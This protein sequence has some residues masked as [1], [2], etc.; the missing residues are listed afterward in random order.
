[1]YTR[2]SAKYSR[3]PTDHNEMEC[4]Y[5]SN[6][7]RQ[8]DLDIRNLCSNQGLLMFTTCK[9]T[10]IP[11]YSYHNH[12]EI[13]TIRIFVRYIFKGD[14]GRFERP[15]NFRISLIPE[16]NI[17]LCLIKILQNAMSFW[18]LVDF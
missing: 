6:W 5:G 4:R 11:F 13:A 2:I 9:A 17:P 1:M 18:H 7:S 3:S 10:F 15:Y 12:L 16:K 14:N 8:I